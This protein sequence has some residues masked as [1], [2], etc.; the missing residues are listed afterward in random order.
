MAPVGNKL[1]VKFSNRKVGDLIIRIHNE[2]GTLLREFLDSSVDPGF[3]QTLISLNGLESGRYSLT[4]IL[5]NE[6][7][8]ALFYKEE[9]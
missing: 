1:V 2:D 6:H 8:K 3:H 4:M 5:N 9:Q 7:R